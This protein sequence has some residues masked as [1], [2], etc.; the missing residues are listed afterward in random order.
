MKLP[1]RLAHEAARAGIDARIAA[2]RGE[3]E[4]V[5]VADVDGVHDMRVASRRLRA[6][7]EGHR[8][9][10]QRGPWRAALGRAKQVTRSL[11]VAR[12][13]DVCIG[14]LDARKADFDNDARFALHHVRRAML[15]LRAE[16]AAEVAHAA[17]LVEDPRFEVEV[18]ALYAGSIPAD[19]CYLSHAAGVISRAFE[20]L[21]G[22]YQ[23]WRKTREEEDL[24]AARIA[25]KKLR[26]H[27]ELYD[28]LYGSWNK[29]FIKQLKDAQE[30][31]GAW[32]DYRILRDH[33]RRFAEDAPPRAA[34]GMPRLLA[35]LDKE[36][37][38][39]LERFEKDSK[40]FFAKSRMRRVHAFFRWPERCCCLAPRVEPKNK[41]TEVSCDG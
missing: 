25:F 16:Q 36:V 24:H 38:A 28:E 8:A 22:D 19:S 20:T 40:R 15:R 34:L 29:E 7:L 9:L 10:F 4:R 2:M 6:G 31:L 21:C 5:R 11:G 30:A 3:I 12:E 23:K 35:E 32:N 39:L 1:C 13:L 33:A 41:E 26:Y 37:I 18:H 17:A 27:C 14:I